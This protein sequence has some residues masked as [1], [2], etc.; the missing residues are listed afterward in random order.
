MARC[1]RSAVRDNGIG[2]RREAL[3]DVFRMFS[4]EQSALERSEGGLGIGLALVKGL[5]ELHGGT[6]EADSAG[7][8][9]GCEFTV[10]LP[11]ARRANFSLSPEEPV[12]EVRV[13]R[14]SILLADDNRDL[15]DM[16][17]QFLEMQG[18]S[19]VKARDGLEALALARTVRPD[20]AILDIGMPGMN[21]YQLAQAIRKEP[22]GEHML[23]VAATG[24]GHDD[25]KGRAAA[26]G[27]DTHITKPFGLDALEAL[28]AHTR[29]PALA[30]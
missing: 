28:L 26:S 17:S 13:K 9:G 5:V 1:A 16:L 14:R 18:H 20:V 12:H 29:Q 19:V 21:G 15:V 22:W 6:V 7:V 11:A 27:F 25:D 23:L 8:G 4:Q 30:G 24:W 2:L 3:R 10:R